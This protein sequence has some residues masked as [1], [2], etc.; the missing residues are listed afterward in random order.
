MLDI[1]RAR[2]KSRQLLHDGARGPEAQLPMRSLERDARRDAC[3]IVAWAG[4]REIGPEIAAALI[5]LDVATL[6]A[7]CAQRAARRDHHGATPATLGAPPIDCPPSVVSRIRHHLVLY[8]P[9]IGA[10]HL[11][12]EFPDVSWRDCYRLI[13]RFRDDLHDYVRSCFA[14]VCVWTAV[15]TVWA[16]D[17]AKP[18]YPIDGTH[19]WLLDVR[20]LASGCILASVP[21]ERADTATAVLVL[22]ALVLAFGAPLVLKTDNGKHLI[23]GHLPA[24]LQAHGITPLLS[25]PYLPSY[26]GACESGHGSIKLHAEALARRNGTPG[27]W[28]SDHV[29]AARLFAIRRTGSDKPVS[30]EQRFEG[31]ATIT[32]EARQRFLNSVERGL[33][34]R[35]L[36]IANALQ[37]GGQCAVYAADSIDRHATVSAL[38]KLGYLAFQSRPVSQPIPFR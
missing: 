23:E 26:N 13:K 15:N 34:D 29:E 4:M 20:D 35:R 37:S 19:P 16:A 28:S 18:D 8:G 25:P 30:A 36:E 24:F 3:A 5:G 1:H 2:A 22:A 21:C 38:V 33:V 11:K 10:K 12:Q 9:G 17:Y 14:Q 32:S 31:R 7:W 27:R 6:H